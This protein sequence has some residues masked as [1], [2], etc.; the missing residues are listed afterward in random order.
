MQ[1]N[2]SVIAT[3]FINLISSIIT[4]RMKQEFKE[5]GLTER[6]SFNQIM[7]RLSSANKYLDGTTKK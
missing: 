4:S 1:Q 3:E 6:F 7:E 5:K 2:T